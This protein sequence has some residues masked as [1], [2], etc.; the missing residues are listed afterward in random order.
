[1]GNAVT[2]PDLNDPVNA[3]LLGASP[4]VEKLHAELIA[5][6]PALRGTLAIPGMLVGHGLGAFVA[7]GMTNDQI[8]EHVLV[9]VA[10][11]RQALSELQVPTT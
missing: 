9:I 6:Y 11:I 3:A 7:N 2:T 10:Q 4:R 8:V 5:A 1:V